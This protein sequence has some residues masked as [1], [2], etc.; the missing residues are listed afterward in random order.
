MIQE[1]P[2]QGGMCVCHEGRGSKG[3]PGRGPGLGTGMEMGKCQTCQSS[4]GHPAWLEDGNS[5]GA[6]GKESEG[7]SQGGW[8]RR[9]QVWRLKTA[10]CEIQGVRHAVVISTTPPSGVRGLPALWHFG[11]LYIQ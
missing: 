7:R 3:G 9:V 11:I 5:I 2:T 8:W 10:G 4:E 1:E 6:V